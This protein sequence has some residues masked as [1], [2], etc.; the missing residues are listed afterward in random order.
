[1]LVTAIMLLFVPCWTIRNTVPRARYLR[2]GCLLDVASA[3]GILRNK[4][5]VLQGVG[6]SREVESALIGRGD[7]RLPTIIRGYH[8]WR[9]GH[10]VRTKQ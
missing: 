1:M 9:A 5:L 8:S 7:M 6:A 3:G 4:T 2:F 10:A